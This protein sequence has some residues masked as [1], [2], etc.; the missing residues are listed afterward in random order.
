MKKVANDCN[1]ASGE[2]VDESREARER[3]VEYAAGE[4]DALVGEGFGFA[5]VNV[6]EDERLC[7]GPPRSAVGKN[8]DTLVGEGNGAR[9]GQWVGVGDW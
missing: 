1:A 9:A 5:E 8:V 7:S 4:G 2:R 6:G 3:L